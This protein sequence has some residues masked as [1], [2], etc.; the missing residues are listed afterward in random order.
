MASIDEMEYY[1]H[2]TVSIKCS[3]ESV[4]DD[5]SKANCYHKKGIS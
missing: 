4:V 3:L 5:E 2:L 1:G